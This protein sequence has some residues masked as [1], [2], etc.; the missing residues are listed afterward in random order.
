MLVL[1]PSILCLYCL[2]I[3][4]LNNNQIVNNKPYIFPHLVATVGGSTSLHPRDRPGR[5][6]S[7]PC[8]RSPGRSCTP[9]PSSAQQT[10]FLSRLWR[11]F[12]SHC[13]NTASHG[14]GAG[15]TWHDIILVLVMTWWWGAMAWYDIYLYWTWPTLELEEVS[16]STSISSSQLLSPVLV[17]I[18]LSCSTELFCSNRNLKIRNKDQD[19][20]S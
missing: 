16:A 11:T 14:V 17:S 7:C 8:W 15:L 9:A 13:R 2:N 6:R 3:Q 4:P 12:L 5:S 18:I 1:T 10:F 20:L 19:K